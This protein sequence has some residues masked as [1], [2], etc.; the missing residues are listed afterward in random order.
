MCSILC[1]LSKG[2]KILAKMRYCRFGERLGPSSLSASSLF[3]MG[4]MIMTHFQLRTFVSCCILRIPNPLLI[5]SGNVYITYDR[6]KMWTS[7]DIEYN[8]CHAHWTNFWWAVISVNSL[9]GFTGT[10]CSQL[11][12]RSIMCQVRRNYKMRQNA[13]WYISRSN[14]LCGS[15]DIGVTKKR[16]SK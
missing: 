9:K 13:A 5:T 7:S 11:I 1:C 14:A 12:S 3:S 8:A 6:P 16:W 4:I 15:I 2:S 10:V